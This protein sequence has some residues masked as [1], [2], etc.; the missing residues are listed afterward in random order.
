MD[1]IIT[2]LVIGAIVSIGAGIYCVH[3]VN[4][5]SGW[6]KRASAVG[7]TILSVICLWLI[8]AVNTPVVT[9]AKTEI[10]SANDM[11]FVVKIDYIKARKCN[12]NSVKLTVV[13]A[14]GNEV[15]SLEAFVSLN[16]D[17]TSGLIY[18]IKPDTL[19]PTHYYIQLEHSCPFGIDI[20]H[21]FD[22]KALPESLIDPTKKS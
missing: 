4:R 14:G 2:L 17:Q 22:I 6:I 7:F 12:I 3:K 20:Y 1:Y 5:S 13:S 18:A 15:D 21:S 8:A 16:V 10:I 19:E 9:E 11:W